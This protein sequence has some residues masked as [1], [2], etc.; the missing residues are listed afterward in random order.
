MFDSDPIL[1]NTD[2]EGGYLYIKAN[3]VAPDG[4]GGIAVN[5]VD[6][7][8]EGASLKSILGEGPPQSVINVFP[9]SVGIASDIGGTSVSVDLISA[10]VQMTIG[11]DLL[12]QLDADGTVHLKTGA[13]IVTDL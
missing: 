1:F 11:G 10:T 9:D 12:F 13:A 5:I 7:T 4:L 2:N 8:G 6:A 3:D